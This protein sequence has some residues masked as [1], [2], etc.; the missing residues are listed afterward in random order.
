MRDLNNLQKIM[1]NKRITYRQL[2][3]ASGMSVGALHKIANFDQSPTQD[4][5]IAIAKGLNMKVVEVFN[6]DY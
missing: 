2:A 6:L 1:H 3:K 5:M 4:T